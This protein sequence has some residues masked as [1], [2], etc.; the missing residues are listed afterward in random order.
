MVVG[1]LNEII[2]MSEKVGGGVGAAKQMENFRVAID[3][4]GLRDLGY[5]GVKF[6]W[7]YIK[8]YGTQIKGRLDHALGF[9]SWHNLFPNARVFHLANSALDHSQ[10]SIHLNKS[11]MQRKRRQKHFKFKSM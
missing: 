6:K 8:R 4:C 9:I 10:L 11:T 3:V 5:V 7:K 2:G 1:E